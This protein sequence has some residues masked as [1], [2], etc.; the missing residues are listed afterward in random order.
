MYS[1]PVDH[2][3]PVLVIVDGGKPKFCYFE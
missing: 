2:L 3:R 1:S